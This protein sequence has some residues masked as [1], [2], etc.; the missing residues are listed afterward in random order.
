MQSF[1][2]ALFLNEVVRI[3]AGIES[4]RSTLEK[5]IDREFEL[6]SEQK[7]HIIAEIETF[8]LAELT[9]H[10][11]YRTTRKTLVSRLFPKK[12]TQPKEQDFDKQFET[13]FAKNHIS[14]NESQKEA[15]SHLLTSPYVHEDDIE[16]ILPLFEKLEEKQLL[17]QYFFPT[18]T[19]GVLQKMGILSEKQVHDYIRQSIDKKLIGKDFAIEEE[20]VESVDADDIVLPTKLMPETDLDILLAGPGKKMIADRIRES[21]EAMNEEFAQ[22]NTLGLKPDDNGKLLPAFQEELAELGIQNAHLFEV[23]SYVRGSAKDVNGDIRTFH[24]AI[25]DIDDDPVKNR[26]NGGV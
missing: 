20:L 25:T 10:L 9:T 11:S 12:E 19:L 23:G 15:V 6:T 14:L 8:S 2:K 26:V 1:E 4:K 16:K 18:I 21:N 7:E 3:G 24:F 17:V 5:L 13:L 22:G